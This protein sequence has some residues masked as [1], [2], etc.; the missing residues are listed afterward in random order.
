MLCRAPVRTWNIFP[1]SAFRRQPNS[2]HFCTICRWHYFCNWK[3]E[4][5]QLLA[6]TGQQPTGWT[7]EQQTE[8]KRLRPFESI[9]LPSSPKGWRG[10]LCWAL[11]TKKDESLLYDPKSQNAMLSHYSSFLSKAFCCSWKRGLPKLGRSWNRQDSRAAIY[12]NLSP[13][14]CKRHKTRRGLIIFDFEL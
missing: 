2:N 10:K 4:H 3:K 8:G 11:S 7:Y 14:S 13:V 1:T 9:Y 12:L 5:R 6:A